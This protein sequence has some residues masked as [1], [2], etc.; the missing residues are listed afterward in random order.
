[1]SKSALYAVLVPVRLIRAALRLATSPR[2]L[3]WCIPPWILGLIASWAAFIT[4]SPRIDR[5]VSV[6]SNLAGGVLQH[7]VSFLGVGAAI[8]AAGVVGLLSVILAGSFFFDLLVEEELFRRGI[9]VPVASN[10]RERATRTLRGVGTDAVIL[11]VVIIISIIGILL[12]F[13]PP[14]ATLSALIGI[15]VLGYELADKPLSIL[16]VPF[17]DRIAI[18]RRNALEC[19]ALGGMQA[20][21]IAIPG[22]NILLLPVFHLLAVESVAR[23]RNAPGLRT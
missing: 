19:I 3:R 10:L 12:S 22:A 15:T 2:L 13:F 4:I 20:L 17:R 1:M 21:I 6:D 8:V 5:W 9:S 16:E 7:V 23:W 18:V 11:S 14:L